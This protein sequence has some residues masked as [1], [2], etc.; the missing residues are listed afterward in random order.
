MI[1]IIPIIL[2]YV[3]ECT[4]ARIDG[5]CALMGD[6]GFVTLTT[7]LHQAQ[8]ELSLMQSPQRL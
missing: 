8:L 7:S 3:Y 2:C 5:I 1:M 6:R 4:N